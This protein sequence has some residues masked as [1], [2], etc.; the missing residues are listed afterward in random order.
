[1]P[2][3]C[4]RCLETSCEKANRFLDRRFLIDLPTDNGHGVPAFFGP[5]H[6][7]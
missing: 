6:A 2:P 3:Y 4:C 7:T 5:A 1:M